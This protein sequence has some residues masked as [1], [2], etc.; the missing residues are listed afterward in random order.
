[1][2]LWKRF[3]FLKLG[4]W[5][6][7]FG[8]WNSRPELLKIETLKTLDFERFETW[9]FEKLKL[10][11]FEICDLKF[12]TWNLRFEIFTTWNFGDFE[13]KNW[14]GHLEGEIFK[15]GNENFELKIW[16]LEFKKNLKIWFWSFILNS[17]QEFFILSFFE[18]LIFFLKFFSFHDVILI[19]LFS[20]NGKEKEIKRKE[21]FFLG[22]DSTTQ[23]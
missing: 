23:L 16:D 21:F 10:E 9:N 2:V 4:I 18:N 17:F 13:F 22:V 7:K 1:M 15:L 8:T 11:V 19:F 6:L 20:R 3:D 12:W 14:V 5:C